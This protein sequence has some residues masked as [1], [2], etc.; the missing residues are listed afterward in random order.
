MKH[1]RL[2]VL[3][4]VFLFKVLIL[5]AILIMVVLV[6]LFWCFVNTFVAY[7]SNV[8]FWFWVVV[9][10]GLI[11]N[12]I[13]FVRVV[14]FSRFDWLSCYVL[15]C[16][17]GLIGYCFCFVCLFVVAEFAVINSVVLFVVIIF[18]L[19]LL[20]TLGFCLLVTLLLVA[21]V[22]LDFGI[23]GLIYWCLYWD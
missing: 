15:G 10:L 19:V 3:L 2:C 9:D 20:L 18:C 7:R 4:L 1:D 14:L 5:V 22:Y 21:C 11:L 6:R 16:Y 8:L 23:C 17:C 13:G 12:L